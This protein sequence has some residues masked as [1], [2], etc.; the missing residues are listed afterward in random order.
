MFLSYAMRKAFQTFVLLFVVVVAA[1]GCGGGGGNESLTPPMPPVSPGGGGGNGDGGNGGGER[2]ADRASFLLPSTS[3]D[4]LLPALEDARY[5]SSGY[6]VSGGLYLGPDDPDDPGTRAGQ[7][8]EYRNAV[9]SSIS[10]GTLGSYADVRL[11]EDGQ[12]SLSVGL[13]RHT[14]QHVDGYDRD[15]DFTPGRPVSRQSGTDALAHGWSNRGTHRSDGEGRW[16]MVATGWQSTTDYGD[17][18]VMG[19]YLLDEGIRDSVRYAVQAGA[20]VSSPEFVRR[21]VAYYYDVPG[22]G[23]DHALG[24]AS[25]EGPTFGMMVESYGSGRD[26]P[27][28]TIAE[29]A[30]KGSVRIDVN[31]ER[32]GANGVQSRTMGGSVYGLSTLGEGR[33]TLPGGERLSLPSG[34]PIRTVINELRNRPVFSLTGHLPTFSSQLDADNR[35]RLLGGAYRVRDSSAWNDGTMTHLAGSYLAA[36]EAS[37][38]RDVLLNALVGN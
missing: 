2:P 9:A 3:L 30:Y 10:S 37:G 21:G 4:R 16:S 23:R 35:P 27:Q 20:F 5:T 15:V 29:A 18:A 22:G 24:E 28:G 11:S 13:A 32:T 38:L 36:T 34:T 1:A 6:L 14:L 17:W 7:I 8:F 31:F 25:Y 26:Q 33:L 19:F 12:G